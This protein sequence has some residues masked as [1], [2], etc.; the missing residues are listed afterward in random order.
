MALGDKPCI[1][2]INVGQ[3]EAVWCDVETVLYNMK[4][5]KR[6]ESGS[7]GTVNYGTLTSSLCQL[8]Q[9]ANPKA[10]YS[11][12]DIYSNGREIRII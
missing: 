9:A 11:V 3:L 2:F 10:E 4:R 6:N 5:K 1:Q 12:C 7:P 8:L